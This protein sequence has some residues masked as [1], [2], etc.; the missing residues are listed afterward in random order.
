TGTS[1]SPR[2]S[3]PN[4]PGLPASPVSALR[5]IGP[6]MGCLLS[7]AGSPWEVGGD[8]R[9]RAT[10]E[11]V[12]ARAERLHR[13]PHRPPTARAWTS[14]GA[15]P[16][17]TSAPPSI[18]HARRHCTDRLSPLSPRRSPPIPPLPTST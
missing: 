4:W 2:W 5:L 7:C 11:R 8:S 10:K 14:H 15:R 6:V 16:P 3:V 13:A 17:P 9:L 12:A 1:L 18:P